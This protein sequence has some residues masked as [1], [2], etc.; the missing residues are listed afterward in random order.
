MQKNNILVTDSGF[1]GFHVCKYFLEKNIKVIGIDN[2]ITIMMKNLK[3]RCANF[4]FKNFLFKKIDIR[5]M[6]KFKI[7]SRNISRK[8]LFI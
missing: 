7:S 4:K 5:K 1:I 2:H 6:L 3:K 8:L